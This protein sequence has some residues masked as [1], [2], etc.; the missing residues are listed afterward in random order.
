MG[1]CDIHIVSF[2]FFLK[3][4]QCNKKKAQNGIRFK[5]FL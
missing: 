4:Q 5:E 1:H 3:K 2:F